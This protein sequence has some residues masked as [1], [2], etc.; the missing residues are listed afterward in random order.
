LLLESPARA[1]LQRF[2]SEW[3]ARVEEL[4][5]SRRLRWSVDVDPIE[6]D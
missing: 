5:M 6:V 1:T 3:L 2:L 4:R